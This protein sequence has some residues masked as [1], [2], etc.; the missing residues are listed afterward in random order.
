MGSSVFAGL[1]IAFFVN[2]WLQSYRSSVRILGLTTIFSIL[3]A[4]VFWMPVYLGLP[5]S[6]AEYRLRL[7][8]FNYSQLPL[9]IKQVLPN[10]I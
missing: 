4:F 5:L 3:L 8:Y 9:W 6:L 10:W 7:P 2:N 1:A